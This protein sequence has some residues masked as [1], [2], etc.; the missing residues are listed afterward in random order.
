M[1]LARNGWESWR[2]DIRESEPVPRLYDFYRLSLHVAS[3][4]I[5]VEL[6]ERPSI[7]HRLDWITRSIV[8]GGFQFHYWLAYSEAEEVAHRRGRLFL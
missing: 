5:K 8:G 3:A 7:E 6:R 2:R 1:F 4:N